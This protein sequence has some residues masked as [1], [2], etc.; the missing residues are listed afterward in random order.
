MLE[1]KGQFGLMLA[2]SVLLICY[3]CVTKFMFY[4][5]RLFI[6]KFI[7]AMSDRR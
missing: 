5:P 7:T 3:N 6:Y 2:N 4:E 1:F